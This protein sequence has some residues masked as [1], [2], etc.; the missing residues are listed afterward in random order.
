MMFYCRGDLPG[1][2]YTNGCNH[3]I[4]HTYNCLYIN[5]R[6]LNIRQIYRISRPC[7]SGRP[8]TNCEINTGIINVI[9]KIK[10]LDKPKCVEKC[11]LYIRDYPKMSARLTGYDV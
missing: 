7:R 9:E 5:G 3:I 6:N 11:D 4:G 8:Y 10:A 1:R 2:P